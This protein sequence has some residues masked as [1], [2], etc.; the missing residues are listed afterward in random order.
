MPP[1]CMDSDFAHRKKD[2]RYKEDAALEYCELGYVL[3]MGEDGCARVH[4]KR[5]I[6]AP[7]C[8]AKLSPA[9]EDLIAAAV[10]LIKR[11]LLNA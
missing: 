5:N 9:S 11:P 8:I 2:L 1:Q 6:I 3:L 4:K 10:Y 7:D